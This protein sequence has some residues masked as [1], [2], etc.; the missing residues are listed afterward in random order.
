MSR[1]DLGPHS[2]PGVRE[3]PP[4]ERLAEFCTAEVQPPGLYMVWVRRVDIHTAG[5]RM[6]K[7][8]AHMVVCQTAYSPGPTST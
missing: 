1:E 2:R 5:G 7:V 3:G 8:V 6:A 4:E